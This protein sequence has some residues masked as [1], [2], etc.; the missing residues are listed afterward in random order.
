MPVHARLRL[1]INLRELLDES[2]DLFEQ[3]NARALE[4][5]PK[6]LPKTIKVYSR[7]ISWPRCE[8]IHNYSSVGAPRPT[9][10]GGSLARRAGPPRWRIAGR[11]RSASC[12]VYRLVEVGLIATRVGLVSV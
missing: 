1:D 11:K 3:S 10:A 9:Y 2:R 8:R 7:N 5:L 6:I 4:Q 12:L